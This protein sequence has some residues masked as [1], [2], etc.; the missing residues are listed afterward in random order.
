MFMTSNAVEVFYAYSHQDEALRDELEKHLSTLWRQ[1]I[2]SSWH[3]R[4]I[5]PGTEWEGQ[6]DE[7]LNVSQ[8]ILLL[9]SSDFLFSN[10]CY[11]V[12]MKRALERHEA[13]TARVIPV[14]LRA[15]LWDGAPFCKLQ[16]LPKDARPITSWPNLDEA[17][18]DV[19]KGIRAAIQ[20]LIPRT[21]RLPTDQRQI[22]PH[23]FHG[24]AKINDRF[25]PPDTEVIALIG[26]EEQA[27][28]TIQRDGIYT[29]LVPK[30]NGTDVTFRV[31]NHTAV[32]TAMWKKSGADILNL[33]VR[34]LPR[35]VR[36]F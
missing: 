17:F 35:A 21:A 18:F 22:P 4:R 33:T 2:I 31:G 29:L 32:Q 12:E 34:V 3:D 6:I 24:T 11:D 9:V 15:C 13:G 25:A 19:A 30:G 28:T 26:G 20:E 36:R 23:V 8:V 1:G 14:I 7:H 5:G 27:S 10:Y 16:A